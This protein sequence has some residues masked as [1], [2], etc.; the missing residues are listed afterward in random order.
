MKKLIAMI[1]LGGLA[2]TAFAQQKAPKWMEK[3]KKAV[4]SI[5]TYKADGT[6]LHNGTGFFIAED[7]KLLSAYSLF[8]GA[9]KAI[10][11]DTNGK[12]YPVSRVLAA[13]ELYDVIKLQVEIPKKVSYLEMAE[14]YLPK[15][16]KK[17]A[18][19][20]V[21]LFHLDRKKKT[22]KL[23]KGMLS[24]LSIVLALASKADFTFLDEPV[25]GLDVVAREPS[26]QSSLMVIMWTTS[27]SAPLTISSCSLRILVRLTI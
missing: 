11:T 21:D 27:L 5:T 23:S 18:E 10:V 17:M 13:D 9:D 14:A 22:L 2:W 12:T 26:E 16:D 4:V 25:S 1:V 6:T 8:K 20:L 19:E 3:Q 24:M 7:G 15:W